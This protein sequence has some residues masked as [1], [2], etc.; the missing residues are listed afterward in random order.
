LSEAKGCAQNDKCGCSSRQ[1]QRERGQATVEFALVCLVI[2]L[3]LIGTLD[4]GRGVFYYD[5]LA[6]AARDGA[7]YASL[8]DGSDWSLAGNSPGTYP[9][10]APYVGTTTIVG[11]TTKHIAGLEPSQLQVVI[12]TWPPEDSGLQVPV[13]VATQYVYQPVAGTLLGIGP[14]TIRAQATMRVS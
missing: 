14:I 11:A 8:L 2:L 4:L 5:V 12:S 1:P 3:F 13:S 6:N 9:S 10:A 7:R